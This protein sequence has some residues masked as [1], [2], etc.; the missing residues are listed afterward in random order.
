MLSVFVIAT[1]Q[2]TALCIVSSWLYGPMCLRV[3][4]CV[5]SLSW[6]SNLWLC[7]DMS[8]TRCQRRPW[9]VD[10]CESKAVYLV[11]FSSRSFV[12]FLASE[13]SSSFLPYLV[14]VLIILVS[15]VNIFRN[16]INMHLRRVGYT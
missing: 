16:S 14:S 10:K 15:N 12:W 2:I 4:I 13:G 8:D 3:T 9:V 6:A 11:T 7:V 1:L 5:V